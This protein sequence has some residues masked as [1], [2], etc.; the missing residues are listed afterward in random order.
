[1]TCMWDLS[2]LRWCGAGSAM[3][4]MRC[5]GSTLGADAGVCVTS[6]GRRRA[7]WAGCTGE[8]RTLKDCACGAG[9]TSGT[10][11]RDRGPAAESK[12]VASWRMARSWSWPSVAKGAA[13]ENLNRASIKLRA[14]SW[15][16]STEDVWGM[17]QLWVKKSTVLAMR[18]AAVDGM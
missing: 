17:A 13:G 5:G 15:A 3:V 7:L 4:G 18:S 16:L 9:E 1:M 2:R 12:I 10:Y 8:R 11:T 14:A 6:A